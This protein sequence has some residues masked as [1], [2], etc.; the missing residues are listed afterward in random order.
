MKRPIAARDARGWLQFLRKR[1]RHWN[2]PG[3]F[4]YDT[5]LHQFVLSV[6]PDGWIKPGYGPT[7]SVSSSAPKKY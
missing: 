3:G 1:K 7:E 4:S 6:V 2:C 5:F